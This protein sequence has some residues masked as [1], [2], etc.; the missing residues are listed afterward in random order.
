MSTPKRIKPISAREASA[1]CRLEAARRLLVLN[2]TH[3]SVDDAS[4][5]QSDVIDDGHFRVRQ[6]DIGGHYR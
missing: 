2:L 4:I 5:F 3:V 1:R 6:D